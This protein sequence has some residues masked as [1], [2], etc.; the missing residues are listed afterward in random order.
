[1]ISSAVMSL[2]ILK[3]L[4]LHKILCPDIAITQMGKA[5]VSRSS[6][7]GNHKLK[8]PRLIGSVDSGE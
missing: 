1:M 6:Q 2:L 3:G 5:S 8:N 4:F 7:M